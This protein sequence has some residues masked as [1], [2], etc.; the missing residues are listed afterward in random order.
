MPVARDELE[1]GLGI[2]R[3]DLVEVDSRLLRALAVPVLT[4]AG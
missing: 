4:I 1:E 3:L 2:D